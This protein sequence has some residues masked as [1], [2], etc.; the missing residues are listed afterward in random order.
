M[1]RTLPD[2]KTESDLFDEVLELP[3]LNARSAYQ[4]LVGLDELKQRLGREAQVLLRPALVDQWLKSKHPAATGLADLVRQRVPLFLFEGDVGTGKTAL[5]RSFGD[6]IARQHK[7]NLRV[8]VLSLNARGSGAVGEMTRLLAGAFTQARDAA[9]VRSPVVLLIDEADALAQNRGNSQMHHEDRAGVNAL[10]RGL[11]G[12]T[13]QTH[14]VLV[15]MCTNRL[16]AVDPAVRR[17]AAG[18]FRF[19]RPGDERRRSLLAGLLTP[20]GFSSKVIEALVTATGDHAGRGYGF[21]YSDLT[22]RLLPTGI[23]SALPDRKLDPAELLKLAK[24][25]E[26]SPPFEASQTAK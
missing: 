1:P 23:L 15:V 3:D 20:A 7:I 6:D 16:D 22:Q 5:A 19:D 25:M 13:G 12:I 21:T 18:T 26:P 9:T 2:Q 10:I 11:D 24:D 14:P 17:R 4:S 8:F